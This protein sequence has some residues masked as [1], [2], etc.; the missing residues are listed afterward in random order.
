MDYIQ[1]FSKYLILYSLIIALLTY[2]IYS[3]FGI[4]G[5]SLILLVP[6]G[7]MLI[8]IGSQKW[9][10]TVYL[11]L[12]WFIIE[13]VLRKWVFPD[14]SSHI[15]LFKYLILLCPMLY[16]IKRGVRLKKKEYPFYVLLL[17]YLMWGF[18]ELLNPRI[19][20]SFE[21]KVLG[22]M[23][24]Y[25]F[26]PLIYF[27]PFMLDSKEKIFKVLH[28]ISI[29]S[30]PIF[31]LGI[32]QYFSPVDST[33][34]KYVSDDIYIATVGDRARITSV[35]SYLSPYTSY[36]TLAMS[37]NF[38]L[39]L[40][41]NNNKTSL[42]YLIISLSLGTL[43]VFMTGSRGVVYV[44]ILI[45]ICLMFLSIFFKLSKKRTLINMI[46][47]IIASFS[48]MLFTK[49]GETAY[50]N[51]MHRVK[52]KGEVRG[53]TIENILPLRYYDYSGLVGYGIGTTYQGA[54]RYIDDKGN[55]PYSEGEY[56]RVF[57]EF[58]FIGL[59]IILLLRFR[60]FFF[61]FKSFK[62]IKDKQLKFLVLMLVIYQ[63]PCILG[64]Q[65]VIYNSTQNAIYWMIIGIIVSINRII[66]TNDSKSFSV[67]AL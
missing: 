35:F 58:G 40:M 37:V 63:I 56:E 20:S 6:L 17:L 11:F 66:K 9:I 8:V 34:N 43:N 42:I 15:F 38:S 46:L 13:G 60:L 29:I 33:I 54:K 28:F 25:S 64:F 31:I 44:V 51:F 23:V 36:L 12:C 30:I 61:S 3:F 5:L 27:I 41:G 1:R 22:V 49:S 19:S 62:K 16:F 24:H 59:I 48:V 55:M 52:S 45:F 57:V 50:D 7:L 4:K 2:F 10:Y 21:L 32:Y 39:L 18:L 67:P 53:R 47:V 26:I 65:S 14:H